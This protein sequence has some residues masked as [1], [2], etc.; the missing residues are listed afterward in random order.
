MKNKY[1]KSISAL[2]LGMVAFVGQANASYWSNQ[3]YGTYSA[4]SGTR[5]FGWSL[6]GPSYT[7]YV[8]YGKSQYC[9]S[10]SN[11]CT[12]SYS[13]A[14]T[15]TWSLATA[16]TYKQAI[17]PAVAELSVAVT[18]TAGKSYT[19]T[20]IYSVTVGPGKTSQYAEFVKRMNGT[21]WIYGARHATGNTRTVCTR[22]GPLHC[23]KHET[24]WEYNDE[25]STV[26]STMT[27]YAS[28]SSSPIH[29]FIIR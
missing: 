8:F 15:L 11:S 24:Q 29:T 23:Y 28:T 7:D 10:G 13:E 19:D 25:P 22:Q 14:V 17:V 1:I 21:A 6:S 9:Q 12:Q 26:I 16:V 3:N 4:Y 20:N 27:G 5:V 18:F 2:V